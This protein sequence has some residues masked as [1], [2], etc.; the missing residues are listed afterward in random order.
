MMQLLLYQINWPAILDL[1]IV[2]TGPSSYPILLPFRGNFLCFSSCSSCS[3]VKQRYPP[4][5]SLS[6]GWVWGKL[7]KIALSA[8]KR[9]IWPQLFKMW[10]TLSTG[11][12][13]IHWIVQFVSL[14]LIHWIVIYLLDST[15][16]LLND[17]GQVD[18]TIQPWNNRGK[19]FRNYRKNNLKAVLYLLE[20]FVYIQLI[21]TWPRLSWQCTIQA[22]LH[23]NST[24]L[25]YLP[26]SSEKNR[27]RA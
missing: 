27:K 3:N 5:K 12:M 16:Q 23:W 24:G 19:C 7:I 1:E 21:V 26:V 22:T 15:I 8:G 10:I 25:L 2:G 13:S 14:I 17:W 18:S 6:I 11:L 9:F 20:M 4:D